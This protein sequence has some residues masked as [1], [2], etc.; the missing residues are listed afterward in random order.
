MASLK[1]F[2]WLHDMEVVLSCVVPVSGKTVE[3]ESKRWLGNELWIGWFA[4]ERRRGV[5]CYGLDRL[6]LC[7]EE[8]SLS[9]NYKSIRG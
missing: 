6:T 2:S 1:T 5:F 4:C 7:R 9:L 3:C 8:D